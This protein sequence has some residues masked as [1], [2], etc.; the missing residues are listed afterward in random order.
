VGFVCVPEFFL[1]VGYH[2]DDG[3]GVTHN[4]F[5]GE[6]RTDGHCHGE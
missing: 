5:G 6:V 4:W 1:A 2:F 3:F